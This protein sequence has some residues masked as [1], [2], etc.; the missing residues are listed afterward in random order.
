MGRYLDI[1]KKVA[2]KKAAEKRA[3]FVTTPCAFCGEPLGEPVDII[4]WK[5]V[6]E[7]YYFHLACMRALELR[8]ARSIWEW[9]LSCLH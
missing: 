3:A 6:R 4:A 9:G 2:D 8:D 7:H 5:G 1:E